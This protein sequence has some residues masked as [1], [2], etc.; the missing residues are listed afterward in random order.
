MPTTA[1]KA[2]GKDPG[3]VY[4][5]RPV[6]TFISRP[7]DTGLASPTFTTL[8]WSAKVPN[9]TKL[10]FKVRSAATAAGLDKVNWSGP[11]SANDFYTATPSTSSNPAAYS[12]GQM[13]ISTMHNGDRF[14]QYR[15]LFE[16]GTDF[17]N[18]PVLDKVEISY[19]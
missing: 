5:R 4:D 16:Q 15:V 11:T 14:I 10:K 17:T 9:K 8:S 12:T 18:T 13:N 19:K 2:L 7:L 6:Q 1:A 3:S